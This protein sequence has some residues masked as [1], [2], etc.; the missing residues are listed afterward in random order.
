MWAKY[1]QKV[2]K[3]SKIRQHQDN[4]ISIA[5]QLIAEGYAKGSFLMG[6]VDTGPCPHRV[7][8]QPVRQSLIQSLF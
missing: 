5:K 6:G 1:L 8:K 7:L 2:K 4:L 3:L